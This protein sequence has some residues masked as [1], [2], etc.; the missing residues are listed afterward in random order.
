MRCNSMSVCYFLQCMIDSID[1][2]SQFSYKTTI[3]CCSL[4][5]DLEA[6]STNWTVLV[7]QK[8][9]PDKHQTLHNKVSINKYQSIH[10]IREH[11]EDRAIHWM[12]TRYRTLRAC[13]RVT[14]IQQLRVQLQGWYYVTHT[15]ATDRTIHT[16]AHKL[17]LCE[18]LSHST[19]TDS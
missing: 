7:N 8:Y 11:E 1:S 19:D 6:I 14:E 5:P 12:P 9:I 18:C 3:R 15:T 4:M 10:P 17:S 16:R 2:F 13:H